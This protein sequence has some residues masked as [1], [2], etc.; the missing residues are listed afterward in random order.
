MEGRLGKAEGNDVSN[1]SR[2]SNDG[3][4]TKPAPVTTSRP[5]AAAA[6]HTRLRP[7]ATHRPFYIGDSHKPTFAA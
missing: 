4:T 1:S 5:A 2:A 3:A 6:T 7:R